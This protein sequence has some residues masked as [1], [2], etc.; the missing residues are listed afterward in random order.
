MASRLPSQWFGYVSYGSAIEAYEEGNLFDRT[1]YSMLIAVAAWVLMSRALRWSQILSRN[2]ALVWFLAIALL[3]VTWSDFPFVAFKRWLRDLGHYVMILVVLTDPR[4]LSAIE[5]LLRRFSY[6][7]IPLSVV[8]VK[9]YPHLGRGYNEWTGAPVYTGVTTNKNLLGVVCLVSATFF[10]WDTV[11]RWSERQQQRTKRILMLNALLIGMSLWL[12]NLADSATS[13]LCVVLACLVI[14]AGHS[15]R[16]R[17]NPSSL[18]WLIPSVLG[19]YLALDFTFN[20]TELIAVAAGRD[21][22]FTGRTEVW[23]DVVRLV[24]NPLLGAGYES[25]WLGDRLEWLWARHEW[26]PNQAHN[27]YIE[28]Y[29]N[30]GL[31]GLCALAGVLIASYREICRQMPHAI[32]S[33]GLAFF[34]VLIFYNATEAAFKGHLLWFVLLLLSVAIPRRSAGEGVSRATEQAAVAT[35]KEPAST[36]TP[37]RVVRPGRPER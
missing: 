2:L 6:A 3:S 13:R 33:L 27:G 17:A 14:L 35:G 19:L 34:A 24:T 7:L 20:I 36:A 12:L 32:A 8:F 37:F 1:I 15:S 21:T 10:F 16:S 9:Y 31:V 22:T 25:F 11:T 18:K 28:M 5:T 29:L 23:K 4:P 30:L 26:R